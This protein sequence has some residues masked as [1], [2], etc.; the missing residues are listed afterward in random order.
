MT[1]YNLHKS[2]FDYIWLVEQLSPPLGRSWWVISSM[3]C[4][5]HKRASPWL[6]HSKYMHVA[7]EYNQYDIMFRVILQQC[8][9]LLPTCPFVYSGRRGCGAV[10]VELA[11]AGAVRMSRYRF[12]ILYPAENM[13]YRFGKTW[14][15]L[16]IGSYLILSCF[17]LCSLLFVYLSIH[18]SLFINVS[19]YI[20]IYTQ[21]QSMTCHYIS[22]KLFEFNCLQFFWSLN[23][24][25][26]SATTHINDQGVIVSWHHPYPLIGMSLSL[27]RRSSHIN[28]EKW[29]GCDWNDGS[30]WFMYLGEL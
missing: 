6:C 17:I 28:G 4:V 5:V 15:G 27:T 14:F 10:H 29:R 2:W 13:K 18:T 30:L 16:S 1:I 8:V 25:H 22:M 21:L 23:T 19:I 11:G 3:F 26:D 7:A 24:E 20:Y 9:Y 12:N